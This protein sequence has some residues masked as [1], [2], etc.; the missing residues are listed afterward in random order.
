MN[1]YESFFN[2]FTPPYFKILAG[3][4]AR[5]CHN[6]TMVATTLLQ[7]LCQQIVLKEKS[8]TGLK[9]LT[10]QLVQQ[11]GEGE[12]E[13]SSEQA[14]LVM[15]AKDLFDNWDRLCQQVA[16]CVHGSLLIVANIQCTCI[17]NFSNSSN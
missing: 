9:L 5:M 11:E 4:L 14:R 12:G 2:F 16:C 15:R 6:I 7:T 8:V 3:A 1:L 10:Q 13:P 17:Q